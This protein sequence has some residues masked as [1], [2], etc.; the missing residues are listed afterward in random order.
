[1]LD[2]KLFT[3]L[4]GNSTGFIFIILIS[5]LLC[6]H[7]YVKFNRHLRERH[8]TREGGS[9]ICHYGQNGVCS[10]LPVDGVSDADYEDHVRRHHVNASSLGAVASNGSNNSLL[11][12]SDRRKLSGS[13]SRRVSYSDAPHLVTEGSKWTV[14]SGSQNLPAVL[15]DP[16]R[17][18]QVFALN[19]QSGMVTYFTS[20]H[21]LT[22]F[23]LSTDLA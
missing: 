1:M 5:F 3:I 18:K 13:L 6:S 15:N 8:C 9:Y 17:G 16:N 4:P 20:V 12:S 23:L 21:S 7:A 10:S 22:T 14:Y 11:I 2:S 19:Y